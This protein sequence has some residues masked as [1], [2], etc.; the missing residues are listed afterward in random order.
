MS[1]L[2][3]S[4]QSLNLIGEGKTYKVILSQS[5]MIVGDG[6]G[7]EQDKEFNSIAISP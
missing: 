5:F 1:I 7:S 6:R 3:P 4:L 2:L